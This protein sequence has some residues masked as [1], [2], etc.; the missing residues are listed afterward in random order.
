MLF[1]L[2][3]VSAHVLHFF[4]LVFLLDEFLLVPICSLNCAPRELLILLLE[5]SV[6]LL[7]LEALFFILLVPPLQLLNLFLFLFPSSL[8]V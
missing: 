8:G 5:L 4:D 1:K 7:E 3:H 6:L 2:L